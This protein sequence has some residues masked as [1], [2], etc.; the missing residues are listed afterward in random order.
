MRT[1]I[2]LSAMPGSGKS[3]WAHLYQKEHDNVIIVSSDDIRE[4]LNGDASD[5]SNDEN[6]WIEYRRQII[7]AAE[8]ED[9]TV[10]GDS[11]NLSNKYRIYYANEAAPLYDKLVL[12]RFDVPY[13][14]C[15]QRNLGR[16]PGRVVPESAMASLRG[17]YE[18]PSED[19]LRL[20]DEV[21]VVDESGVTSRVK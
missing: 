2:L 17:E 16:F 7:E 14:V 4:M 6:V 13:E 15:Q 8:E 12:V 5:V 20:Y 19:A 10:I 1:F 21:Y 9:V 18:D 11:T 3:T